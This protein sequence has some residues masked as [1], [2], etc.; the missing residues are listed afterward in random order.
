MIYGRMNDA[1]IAT[2]SIIVECF[3]NYIRLTVHRQSAHHMLIH[4]RVFIKRTSCRSARARPKCGLR[5]PTQRGVQLKCT[6][7][8]AHL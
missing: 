5:P 3:D 1:M 6:T 8:L 7:S 4:G 2:L